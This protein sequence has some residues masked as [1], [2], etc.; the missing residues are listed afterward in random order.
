MVSCRLSPTNNLN[1][2]GYISK[3][4]NEEIEDAMEEYDGISISKSK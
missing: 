2:I 3:P 4:T 1:A